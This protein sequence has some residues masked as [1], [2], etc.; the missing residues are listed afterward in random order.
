[1]CEILMNTFLLCTNFVD[2]P[3]KLHTGFSQYPSLFGASS[4]PRWDKFNSQLLQN[5][6]LATLHG[7]ASH[8]HLV[9]AQFVYMFGTKC[10]TLVKL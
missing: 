10:I 4:L 3:F 6:L 2:G 5:F 1:M 9:Q 8:P 7:M